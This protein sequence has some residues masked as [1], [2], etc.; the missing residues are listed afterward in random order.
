MKEIKTEKQA[1][2]QFDEQ[3]GKIEL[4]CFFRSIF[5]APAFISFKKFLAFETS[6]FSNPNFFNFS[7]L[8]FSSRFTNGAKA[9]YSICILVAVELSPKSFPSAVRNFKTS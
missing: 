8:A 9:E 6:F 1:L 4:R 5:N 3:Y 7:K 2:M